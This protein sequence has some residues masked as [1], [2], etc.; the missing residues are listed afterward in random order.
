MHV[1][2]RDFAV[3]RLLLERHLDE[4]AL[5]IGR[6]AAHHRLVCIVGRLVELD[7][8]RERRRLTLLERGFGLAGNHEVGGVEPLAVVGRVR[9][10][11]GIGRPADRELARGQ[12]D[13]LGPFLIG[14][15]DL[16]LGR[17]RARTRTRRSRRVRRRPGRP[18]RRRA[19]TQRTRAYTAA[20]PEETPQAWLDELSE[21][22]RIP[23]VSADSAHAADVVRAGEWVRDF[24]RA[25]GGEA[26]LVP[27]SR[28]CA[29]RGRRDPGL[30]GR[31]T[32]RPCSSTATSTSSRP[33]RSSSG[34]R[35]RSSRRSAAT[36]STRA[37]SPTTRAT[38]TSSSRRPRCWPPRAR[39]P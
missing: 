32:R 15:V 26:E 17:V 36:G 29:A 28:A 21:F 6:V 3:G 27:T 1:P 16:P 31:R 25:A 14:G 11:V 10:V 13:R 39:C 9:R 35:R 30:D 18:G 22:L 19:S 20:M 23:S 4:A 2:D 34:T 7:A 24:V 38:S 33:T 5:E 12:K 8:V 37:A